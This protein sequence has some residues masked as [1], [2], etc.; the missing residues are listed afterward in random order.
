MAW[1]HGAT[2]R[3][4]HLGLLGLLTGDPTHGECVSHADMART[5]STG[6]WRLHNRLRFGGSVVQVSMLDFEWL[7]GQDAPSPHE[8]VFTSLTRRPRRVPLSDEVP[9]VHH[10]NQPSHPLRSTMLRV[11]VGLADGYRAWFVSDWADSSHD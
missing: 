10:P 1:E 6:T 2:T 7:G 4:H 3:G 9:V 5:A 8:A 11:I